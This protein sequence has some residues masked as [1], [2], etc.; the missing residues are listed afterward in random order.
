VVGTTAGYIY[1]Y[2]VKARNL[3]GLS[4]LSDATSIQAAQIPDPPI[5]IVNVEAITTATDIGLQWEAPVFNGGSAIIDYRLWS[6][7]GT[8]GVTF[9]EVDSGLTSL[10]YTVD[11]D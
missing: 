4:A 1:S 11:T 6:D 2:K 3:V 7:D 5:N 10:T 8:A 9:T